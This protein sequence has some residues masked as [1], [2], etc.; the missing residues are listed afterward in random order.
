M[1]GVSRKG[2][3]EWHTR[4]VAELAGDTAVCVFLNVRPRPVHGCRPGD[5]IRVVAEG[6]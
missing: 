1:T 2:N 3:R 6:M 4:P 5:E